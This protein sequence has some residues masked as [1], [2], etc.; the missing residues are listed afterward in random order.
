MRAPVERSAFVIASQDAEVNRFSGQVLDAL[1]LRRV[2]L[3]PGQ[4]RQSIPL[5]DS[6]EIALPVQL[7]KILPR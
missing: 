1:L 3:L 6:I 5:G 2:V 7:G 4:R